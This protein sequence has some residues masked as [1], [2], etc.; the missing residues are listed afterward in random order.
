MKRVER[1]KCSVYEYKKLVLIYS[2]PL[3][4]GDWK[5]RKKVLQKPV[6]F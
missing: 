2:K 4:V 3:I 6:R 1:K 5:V